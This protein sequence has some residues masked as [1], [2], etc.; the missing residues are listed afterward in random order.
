MINNCADILLLLANI[1]YICDIAYS[2]ILKVY[3]A[4]HKFINP[5]NYQK[6]NYNENDDL[7][8]V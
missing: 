2:K 3:Y 1:Y 5:S 7:N 8:K 6:S 4:T